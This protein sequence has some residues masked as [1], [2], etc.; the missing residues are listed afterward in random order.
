MI[1]STIAE[2]LLKEI[3][4]LNKELGKTKETINDLH[5]LLSE[6]DKGLNKKD[7]NPRVLIVI[8]KL[9]DNFNQYSLKETNPVAQ[10]TYAQNAESSDSNSDK[11]SF[12]KLKSKL[13]FYAMSLVS[14]A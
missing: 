9:K 4:D 11:S 1:I 13:S 6:I 14:G 7:I 8:D 12:S 3:N 2:L 10:D 5:F